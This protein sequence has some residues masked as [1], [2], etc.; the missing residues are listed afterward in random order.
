MV[1]DMKK[2]CIKPIIDLQKV[3][4]SLSAVGVWMQVCIA[5]D[6]KLGLCRTAQVLDPRLVSSN[7]W[8]QVLALNN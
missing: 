1:W 6:S 4:N 2:I 5:C 7:F 3:A 8:S